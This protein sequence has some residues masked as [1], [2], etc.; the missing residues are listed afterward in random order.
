LDP[1]LIDAETNLGVIEAQDGRVDDAIKLWRLAFQNAPDRSSIGLN[2]A[3]AYCAEG[4]LPEARNYI[5]RVLEFNP[6]QS[7]AKQMMKRLN[8]VSPSCP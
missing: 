3:R 2:L 7:V 1:S 4:K 5:L 8:R 6:D